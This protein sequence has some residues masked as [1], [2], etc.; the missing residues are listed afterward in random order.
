MVVA[1]L[2][3]SFLALWA[4]CTLLLSSFRWFQRRQPLTDRL[5]PRQIEAA[6]WVDDVEAWLQQ[7]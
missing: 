5:V 4:G 3:G 2:V 1:L 7:P 6:T